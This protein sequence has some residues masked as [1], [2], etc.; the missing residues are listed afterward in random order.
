MI[1]VQSASKNVPP[2]NSDQKL[3]HR[4]EG[5]VKRQHEPQQII[6]NLLAAEIS[7]KQARSTKYH[8]TIAKLPRAKE[9]KEFDFEAARVNETL[10][11]DLA[12]GEPLDHQRNLVLIGGNSITRNGYLLITSHVLLIIVDRMGIFDKS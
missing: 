5:A 10:F 2:D 6:G 3:P 8:M 7:D 9:I 12:T 1:S 4:H 11:P